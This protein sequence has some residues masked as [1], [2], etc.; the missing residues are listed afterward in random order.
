LNPTEASLEPRSAG[1]A[2]P[3]A[4]PRPDRLRQRTASA[5]GLTFLASTG[6]RLLTIV[7]TLVLARLLTPHDF[8]LSNLA[9]VILALV[10]PITDIGIAQGLIR[11]RDEDLTTVARTAFWLVVA[12]GVALYIIFVIAAGPLASFYSDPD[13]ALVLQV[14]GIS[15][16]VYAVSRIPSALLER[17]LLYKKKV[18]PEVVASL[19][20]ALIAIMLAFGGYGYWS[21]VIATVARSAAI[22][23]GVFAVTGWRPGITFDIKV[24]Q[25]LLSYARVLLA[26]SML[27]LAYTNI[28]NMIVGKV[29]GVTALGFYA[30]AYNLGNLL[31]T[32]I[33]GAVG[34]GLFPAYSRMLPDMRRVSKAMLSILRYTSLVITPLTVG[35]IVAVPYLIPLVLGPRWIP[36]TTAL[37]IILVYGWLR[38]VA[39]VYWMLMLAADLRR[40]TLNINLLSLLVALAAALPIVYRWGFVGIAAEFTALEVFRNVWMA[41]VVRDKF[42]ASLV[43]QAQQ[44]WPGLAVSIVVGV[45]LAV[46]LRGP[47]PTA[48]VVLAELAAA[49]G[50]YL[51]LLILFRQL[52]R[53]QLILAGSLLQKRGG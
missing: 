28:D 33:A 17:E 19:I 10:L 35:G 49:A 24:A 48:F 32:Q 22:S 15:V 53:E 27:R 12:M 41:V 18:M 44:V 34:T 37:Q 40:E 9:S 8:G 30:M 38:S 6:G 43:A 51:A 20:Y 16:V 13:L 4:K 1:P 25:E 11:G 52:G 3:P 42:G 21:I 50:L 7:T 29:L 5:I 46:A 39:P 45:V 2:N 26:S 36:M 14:S 23:I 31:A 47:E